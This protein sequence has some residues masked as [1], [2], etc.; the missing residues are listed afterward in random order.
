ME[1]RVHVCEEDQKTPRKHQYWAR[2]QPAGSMRGKGRDHIPRLVLLDEDMTRVYQIKD[3]LHIAA[4]SVSNRA[5][6]FLTSL[7]IVA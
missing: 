4:V 1:R 2:G 7:P 5:R 6:W 3:D